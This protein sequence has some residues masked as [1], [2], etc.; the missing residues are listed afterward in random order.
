MLEISIQECRNWQEFSTQSNTNYITVNDLLDMENCIEFCLNIAKKEDLIKINDDEIINK[1][2]EI[3]S[4]NEKIL[5]CIQSYVNNFGQIKLFQ[6]SIDK[7]IA[8]KHIIQGLFNS[9]TY[10]LSN[11]ERE[12]FKSIYNDI[13]INN[14][15]ED[16]VELIFLSD[17]KK[18][19]LKS[20]LTKIEKIL[21]IK[22]VNNIY[23]NL[24]E[25]HK[26]L[27][28]ECN[29]IIIKYLID[30]I[31]YLNAK[32]FACLIDKYNIIFTKIII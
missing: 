1:L 26:D 5:V 32:S 15:I 29:K 2:K 20:F 11:E 12:K 14:F 8:L 28:E 3:I 4:K 17:Q 31:E 30:H 21:D 24:M 23:F 6:I 16:I 10:F 27:S 13:K 25:K 18:V 7:S 9:L 19:D 22:T